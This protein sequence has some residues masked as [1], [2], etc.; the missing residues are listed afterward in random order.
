MDAGLKVMCGAFSTD[1]MLLNP[2]DLR[3]FAVKVGKQ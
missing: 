2:Y 1:A 3:N